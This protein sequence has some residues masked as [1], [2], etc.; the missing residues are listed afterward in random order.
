MTIP[1]FTGFANFFKNTWTALT[2]PDTPSF[3][4]KKDWTKGRGA[5][6]PAAVIVQREAMWLGGAIRKVTGEWG[7]HIIGHI[8]NGVTV[9]AMPSGIGKGSI[10][11]N[12]RPTSQMI[13]FVKKDLTTDQANIIIGFLWGSVGKAYAYL[14]LAFNFLVEGDDGS[15]ATEFCSEEETRAYANVGIKIAADKPEQTSPGEIQV[16]LLSPDGVKENWIIWD[17]YNITIEDALKTG[18]DYIKS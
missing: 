2:G 13:A 15:N 11:S 3:M 18:Y 12:E 14:K 1:F 10:Q 16:Y 4:T 8:G 9:E 5:I 7:N 6:P 17:T